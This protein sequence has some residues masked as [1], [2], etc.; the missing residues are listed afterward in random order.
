MFLSRNPMNLR[1]FA[2]LGA[3]LV[4]LS[5]APSHAQ[6]PQPNSG[7][8]PPGAAGEV[9]QTVHKDWKLVWADEFNGP[10]LD[11]SKWSF[12]LNGNGGGNNELQYY[13][14]RP[15]NAHVGNGRL[16]ITARKEKFRGPDGTRE[17][18]SA[19]LVTKGKGDWRYGRFEARIKFPKGRG[20]W[21]A[22][23]MMPTENV[24]GGW[25][26]SGE[27]DI[28]ELIGD[29][30]DTLYGTLH[31]GDQ[32]PRNAQSGDKFVLSS[33]NFSD[34]FHVIALEWEQREIRW[35][36]DGKLCQA[37]SRWYSTAAP[38]PA[39]F[40]QK[41]FII[42]NVAVGGAWP[43]PPVPDTQFP[44]SMEVDYVRV[45]QPANPPN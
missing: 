33:G 17:Y 16:F 41:F 23:W 26:R 6:Q 36:V 38:Y 20:Y 45:Y 27:I 31:Y 34:D 18:T 15:E 14:D 40:D 1:P 42:L 13:T 28:V 43:G 3:L 10:S 22:F 2:S 8:G 32:W 44:Q 24:Y 4:L 7:T 11:T 19:R 9:S 35:Y 21:P 29:K 5:F 30:P 25:A 12:E 39:P 37:Q